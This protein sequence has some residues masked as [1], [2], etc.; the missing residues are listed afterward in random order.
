MSLRRKKKKAPSPPV[1]PSTIKP[2][3]T[4]N[5]SKVRLAKLFFFHH[6]HCFRIFQTPSNTP[7]KKRPAPTPPTSTP[8]PSVAAPEFSPSLYIT[9]NDISASEIDPQSIS[10]VNDASS[11][12]SQPL[13]RLIPLEEC[14]IEEGST[15]GQPEAENVTYRRR[16]VPLRS[17]ST[18][19][20][21]FENLEQTK[22]NKEAQNRQRQSEGSLMGTRAESE[23]TD[24][25]PYSLNKSSHGKW[26]RRKGPA[27]ALPG[28]AQPQRRI[29]QMLPLQDI[30]RELEVIEVQQQGLEKQGVMLEKM[31]RE[32]CE[33]SGDNRTTEEL[34]EALPSTKN[35]K[36]VE[37]LILQ[38][39][40]LVNEKNELFR[41]QAEL[42]Y[43]RRAHRLEE[44]QADVEYEIRTL[45]AQP[46]QNKTDSDKTKE[47]A[48]IAR[49]VEIVQLRNEVVDTLDRD[50]LREAEE[51]LVSFTLFGRQGSF[52]NS[53][54]FLSEH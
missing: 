22:D 4:T 28:Y 51:D 19:E 31:I 52:F 12:I 18:T 50:R 14:L 49:L 27:P 30:R 40:E 13:R 47:E 2:D 43:L 23:S 45:M 53:V 17:Q 15:V 25:L 9:A 46:E 11:D 24:S 39:F 54:A 29:L 34:L 44:E 10:E 20:E 37:E 1:P 38:L 41:R 21:N 6:F 32:R 26:K 16:I 35:P 3:G 42:M 36:E 8:K 7:R 33:G 5:N 48:L